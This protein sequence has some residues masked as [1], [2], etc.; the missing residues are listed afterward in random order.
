M[1]FVR[2]IWRLVLCSLFVIGL[3]YGLSAHATEPEAQGKAM[4][5]THEA[6]EV[7]EHEEGE[8]AEEAQEAEAEEE[9]A[10]EEESH[11]TEGETHK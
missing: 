5:E 3:T 4:H 7:V 2:V 10:T 11:E 9:T 6:T 8:A 1:S